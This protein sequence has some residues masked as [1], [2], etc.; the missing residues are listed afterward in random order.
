MALARS[1]VVR[2][3]TGERRSR[4]QP[5]PGCETLAQKRNSTR[6]GAFD[7]L[8]RHNVVAEGPSRPSQTLNPLRLSG[9]EGLGCSVA[10][11]QPMS[12]AATMFGKLFGSKS[13]SVPKVRDA[14]GRVIYAIGDV[15][16]QL[17]L[18]DGLLDEIAEDFNALDREDGP[19]LVLLGDYCDRGVQTAEVI[20]RLIAMQ[21]VALTHSAY[22]IRLL[23]GNHEE[24]LLSFLEDSTVGP[25]WLEYGG[26]ETL[27]SYGVQ[28]PRGRADPEQWEAV[29]E[30]FVA[31][32]P[33]KHRAFLSRLE[34]SATYGDYLFV[35]AGVRPG[36]TLDRQT[37]QD[38]LWIRGDFLDW[39]HGLPLTVVHGHTPVEVAHIG[40][41]R[42]NVDT[43]AYATGVLTAVRVGVGPPRLL[44]FRKGAAN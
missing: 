15:H 7:S 40:P 42:I 25:A 27:T 24:T 19:V 13:R 17:P 37:A 33:D 21:D 26:G 38:L 35:H 4:S 18:L 39:P 2:C 9:N 29:R 41:D 16:G 14:G 10:R 5:L 3:Y 32:L 31:A 6:R 1:G 8:L 30:A 44:Q 20:D 12:M 23:M 11:G 28:R 36:V 34:L 22:D 43:G